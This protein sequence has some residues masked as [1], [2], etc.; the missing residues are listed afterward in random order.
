[1]IVFFALISVALSLL[2]IGYIFR[3]FIDHGLASNE[4][5]I[6][7]NATILICIL[8][9][10]F[11]F[12]SFL[13]SY[14]INNIA[15]EVTSQL[16]CDMYE[17][18]LFVDIKTFEEL[19]V[20]DVISRLGPDIDAINGLIVNFLSFFIRNILMLIGAVTLMF[21]Q[22]PKLSILAII[23]IPILLLPIIG[24]SKFV[25]RLSRKVLSSQA[26]QTSCIEENFTGIR[27][28][29]AYNSQEYQANLFNKNMSDYNLLANLR[30]KYRSL[31]FALTISIIAIAII[32]IIWIG[33]LD[34]LSGDISSG[35]MISFIYY[36]IMSA[37]SAGGI[38]EM[39]S[40]IQGP[41]ASI[42]RVMEIK[43][44][45]SI[46]K[47][48]INLDEKID[49]GGDISFVNVTFSYPSRSNIT[50]LDN[51]S[52]TLKNG[53][54]IGI[55]GRSGSGKSTL[56]QLLLKFYDYDKGSIFIS[57]QKI[58]AIDTKALRNKIAYVEQTPMIFS[59][60][61]R[62]NILFAKPNA[63][64]EELQRVV[65]ACDIKSFT[66][67]LKNGIDTPIGEKGTRLSGG[68]KQ[69]IA[70]ARALIYN[71]E[72][73]LL[74][75]ATSAL[76][77]EGEKVVLTNLRKIFSN[78]R[79]V[80]IA[81]RISSIENADRILLIDKGKVIDEGTHK[82]LIQNSR[83]YKTLYKEQLLEK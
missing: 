12:G 38:I 24:L 58:E 37:L 43:K 3:Y 32:T 83:H 20:G 56:L 28:L 1:M 15:L 11:A 45:K 48:S 64:K 73:L 80:S 62:D 77:S 21:L 52:L 33:S 70:I 19:K 79:I 76:D 63:S 5:E 69:R 27:T 59:G 44:L 54:F 14:Y 29:H 41:I 78:R 75:E 26:L 16:K 60:S 53:N 46:T 17:K 2:S 22:S 50:V 49:F 71:P 18:L 61:V 72:V 55:V 39:F 68:Q 13:R 9:I 4:I 25:K 67:N 7:N 36:A 57:N 74:D 42:E 31:F 6:I 81:H 82:T 10:V 47:Q 35:K 8:I 40:E 66:S 23:G 34:I 65:D 30:L 51:I